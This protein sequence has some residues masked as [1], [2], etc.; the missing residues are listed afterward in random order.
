MEHRD[1][2]PRARQ[3]RPVGVRVVHR[4]PVAHLAAPGAGPAGGLQAA[5]G[6]PG[7]DPRPALSRVQAGHGRHAARTSFPREGEPVVD[8]VAPWEMAPRPE[9]LRAQREGVLPGVVGLVWDRAGAFLEEAFPAGP[10]GVVGWVVRRVVV[11]GPRWGRVRETMVS[12]SARAVGEGGLRGR[13]GSALP[14]ARTRTAKSAAAADS[15]VRPGRAIPL[16][17]L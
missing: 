1:R 12:V 4:G 14:A 6:V 7:E 11:W 9:P 17:D 5:A 16:R 13:V 3:V 15:T 2:F 8:P 10:L